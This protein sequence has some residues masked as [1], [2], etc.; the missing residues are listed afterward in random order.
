ITSA[1]CVIV[2]V[3]PQLSVAVTA[4]SSAANTRFAQ[5]TVASAGNVVISG[6]VWSSTVIVWLWLV[7]FPHTSVA[8]YVRVIVYRLAQVCPLI[9][10]ASCVI[11]TVPPQLSVAVTA[12]SSAATTRFAQLTVASAGNVVI[13]G[14]VWSS[15]VIVWLW[16]VTFPHTSVAWYVRVIVYR[17]AQVCPL[18][19]SASCVIVT[20]PPQLSV[21][22]T[23]VSSA[24]T[25]RFPQLT[26]ATAGNV[27]ISG[28]VWSSTV[29]V[30]LWLVTFPH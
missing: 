17:L 5:L 21:A 23:A 16:L 3:P 19:T 7:T 28:A 25:P 27:V 6:P 2:T 11:V 10:S 8:W 22:V 26:V 9:T 1:S 24:A 13:S 14:P 18:I 15:T 12:V 29:I 20:V 4:V 30:W